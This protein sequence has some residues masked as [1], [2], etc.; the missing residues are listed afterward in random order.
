MELT[1]QYQGISQ[2]PWMNRY[3]E[4][5]LEKLTRY[6]VSGARIEVLIISQGERCEVSLTISTPKHEHVFENEGFDLYEA[7]SGAL[8]EAHRNLSREHRQ[9]IEKVRQR[10]GE[11]LD[12]SQ[13]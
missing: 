13:P 12:L 7:F 11:N 10:F 6:L 9:L 5:Q 3:L 4:G 2:S 1:I 8:E